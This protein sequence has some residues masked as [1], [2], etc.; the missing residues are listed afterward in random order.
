MEKIV[1]YTQPQCPPCEI[2]KKYFHENGI[3]YIEKD[4]KK[5]KRALK[6]LTKTY[7]SF[8]TPTVVIG[9]KVITGFN[10]NE[11]EKVL[12]NNKEK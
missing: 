2:T 8:S 10:I 12:A 5:D 3:E 7:K 4:V 9:E 11:I 6:E 1:L